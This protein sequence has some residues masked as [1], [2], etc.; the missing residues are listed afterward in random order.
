MRW[1]ETLTPLH[2]AG[3]SET[4]ARRLAKIKS[5]ERHICDKRSRPPVSRCLLREYTG[6][7]K[8]A[9]MKRPKSRYSVASYRFHSAA[10]LLW[11]C[12]ALAV[13]IAIAVYFL[14]GIAFAQA[15]APDA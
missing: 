8:G 1:P 14:V 6:A 2:H 9:L 7:D 11:H 15:P 12:R 3:T 13:L 10:I 4:S 5:R